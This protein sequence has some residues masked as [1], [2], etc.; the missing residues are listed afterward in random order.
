[1]R[2]LDDKNRLFGVINPVDLIVLVAIVVAVLVAASF[3]F[4]SKQLPGT[5]K[6]EDIQYTLVVPAVT[7][8]NDEYLAKGETVSKL[9]SGVLGTVES[10]SS[11]P[12]RIETLRV[13]GS[14][15][16]YQS[17]VRRDVSIVVNAKGEVSSQGFIIG[18]VPLRN[19][20]VVTVGTPRFEGKDA[21][22]KS[23]KA[24]D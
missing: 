10:F 9:G 2:V 20:T 24:V 13:D 22:I 17:I 16:V 15:I 11:A 6:L 18:G 5:A 12:S 8:F 14:V 19:N 23:M 21:I 1:M 3:L 7:G 4:G